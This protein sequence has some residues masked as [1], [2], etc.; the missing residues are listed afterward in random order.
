MSAGSGALALERRRSP[1]EERPAAVSRSRSRF[2][3]GLAAATSASLTAFAWILSTQLRLL[4]NMSAPAWD[5]G[6]DHNVIWNTAQGR[7][8]ETSFATRNFLGIHFEP[9]MA[10]VAAVE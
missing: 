1:V 8:F 3:W 2:D 4:N 7:W 10:L 5:L 9:I 6:Y